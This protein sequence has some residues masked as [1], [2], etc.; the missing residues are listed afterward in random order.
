MSSAE[1]VDEFDNYISS[2]RQ[3]KKPSFSMALWNLIRQDY[4]HAFLYVVPFIL[5]YLFQPLF[6]RGLLKKLEDKEDDFFKGWGGVSLSLGLTFSTM[7]MSISMQNMWAQLLSAGA[8]ARAA[9][10]CYI[11]KKALKLAPHSRQK[12]SV[13]SLVTLMTVDLD[14]V[15][16]WIQQSNWLFV[17]PA[18]IFFISYIVVG[19]IGVLP[20]LAGGVV[21]VTLTIF[22][23]YTAV[24]LKRARIKVMRN[25]ERRVHLIE[26]LLQGIRVIKSYAWE[27]PL[28]NEV[29]K[30]RKAELR[31][32]GIMLFFS[33]VSL[34]VAFITPVAVGLISFYVYAS[35]GNELTASTVFTTFAAIN[36]LR[37]PVKVI[38]MVI[39]R[40]VEAAVSFK[41][42]TKFMCLDELQENQFLLTD[43]S[44]SSDYSLTMKDSIF[45]WSPERESFQVKIPDL[46]L[47]RGDLVCLIGVVGCGKTSL[48]SSILGEMIPIQGSMTRDKIGY[49]SQKAWIQNCSLRDAI[50]FGQPF[51]KDRYE[52]TIEVAQLSTDLLVLPN[53]DLTE[54]GERGINLSG[55]QKQRVAIARLIYSAK[56]IDLCIFDDPL[57][58]LDVHVAS[59]LF[60]EGICGSILKE[61]TR[62]ISLNSHY[63]LLKDADYIIVME[64][65]SI[66]SQGNY[67]EVSKTPLFKHLMSSME[68]DQ[69]NG[70]HMEANG[71]PSSDLRRVA[72][73]SM[74][75]KSDDV[76]VIETNEDSDR[77]A[78]PVSNVNQG[79]KPVVKL[80]KAEDRKI[81]AV[82]LKTLI[83]YYD[84]ASNGKN[85]ILFCFFVLSMFVVAQGIRTVDDIFLSLWSRDSMNLI[86][87][88]SMLSL[89]R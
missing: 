1:T 79:N 36:L 81:G 14:R 11:F 48:L 86:Y 47:K 49:V 29:E 34:S 88:P 2:E 84:A 13:G 44:S 69:Q 77:A 4:K 17:S 24:V 32:L 16:Y 40:Y 73:P 46:K 76:A 64:D 58:A 38:P 55:G 41:R 67:Y 12:H 39:A 68:Q 80:V 19:E 50:L 10:M 9:G 53:G 74:E 28:A 87:L 6:I 7:I 66:A 52:Q 5:C 37:L 3:K 75:I 23:Y 60:K 54:I 85:G 63:H 62:I 26:E 61:K 56:D 21:L 43:K 45:A 59:A 27:T 20:S 57:S 22:S 35:Q 70:S 15:F 31:N 72:I 82:G 83:A 18:I 42:L 51:D 89:P 33:A 25:T 8:K 30:V 65:G 78:S 71:D